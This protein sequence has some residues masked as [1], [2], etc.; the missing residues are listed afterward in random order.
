MNPNN[1][2][3]AGDEDQVQRQP[4]AGETREK[5]ERRH[6]PGVVEEG[7]GDHLHQ[8]DREAEVDAAAA[9]ELN[10]APPMPC[11]RSLSCSLFFAGGSAD[12]AGR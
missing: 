1:F 8:A 6:D 7:P 11:S 3:L 10:A 5:A 12:A 9:D 2:R 4:I